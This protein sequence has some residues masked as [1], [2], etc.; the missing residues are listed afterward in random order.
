MIDLQRTV[1]GV[2]TLITVSEVEAEILLKDP[3]FVLWADSPASVV[4]DSE[5]RKGINKNRAAWAKETIA[6]D[7][8]DAH[9][10]T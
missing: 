4:P 3:R 2:K 5:P 9:F 10:D 6:D 1:A 7:K 8:N